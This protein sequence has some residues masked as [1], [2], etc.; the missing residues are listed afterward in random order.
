VIVTSEWQL[1]DNCVNSSPSLETLLMFRCFQN[2]CDDAAQTVA[3]YE[4]SRGSPECSCV[5]HQ[6]GRGL[7][8]STSWRLCTAPWNFAKRLGLRQLSAAFVFAPL[9]A[10]PVKARVALMRSV[11]LMEKPKPEWVEQQPQRSRKVARS[12]REKR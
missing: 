10:I 4:I 11:A 5:Q 1:C 2:H 12:L 3:E 7:P 6:S 9:R 8:H